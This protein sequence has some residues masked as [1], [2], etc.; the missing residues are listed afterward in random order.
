M[1]NRQAQALQSFLGINLK[2]HIIIQSIGGVQSRNR[3]ESED[4]QE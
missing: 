2:S 3:P 4:V 1:G